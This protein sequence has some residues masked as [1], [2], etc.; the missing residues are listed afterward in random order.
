MGEIEGRG[1]TW[2]VREGR[3]GGAPR[4]P[5][6]GEGVCESWKRFW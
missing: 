5:V 1:E 6:E 3:G 2:E 4:P